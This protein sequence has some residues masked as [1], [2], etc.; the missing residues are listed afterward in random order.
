V[1]IGLPRFQVKYQADLIGGLQ[2]LGMGIA[3]EKERADF[4]AMSPVRPL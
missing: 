4:S 2:S 3:F 1:R